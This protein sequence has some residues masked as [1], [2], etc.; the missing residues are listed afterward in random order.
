[1]LN[2]TNESR[3]FTAADNHTAV[4]VCAC[5]QLAGGSHSHLSQP[6]LLLEGAPVHTRLI[7][8]HRI[9]P[10]SLLRRI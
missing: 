7:P 1:M 8:V 4:C 6:Q 10:M 2:T 9:Q 5:E 3:H